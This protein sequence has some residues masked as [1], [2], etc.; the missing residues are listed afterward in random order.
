[1]KREDFEQLKRDLQAHLDREGNLNGFPQERFGPL[2]YPQG[3]EL[4]QWF[5]EVSERLKK[6]EQERNG[7]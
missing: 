5:R 7:L 1:V 2:T 4:R 3:K 6:K